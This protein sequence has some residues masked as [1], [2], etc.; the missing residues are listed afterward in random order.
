MQD[1]DFSVV[2]EAGLRNAELARMTN[3]ARSTPRYWILGI[4]K[5]TGEAIPRVE[6]V[7]N[8]LRRAVDAGVLPLPKGIKPSVRASRIDEIYLEYID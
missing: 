4:S 3:V 7:L 1:L 2:Q 5:P 8:G 6:R